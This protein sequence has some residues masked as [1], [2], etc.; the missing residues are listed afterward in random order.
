MT[1]DDPVRRYQDVIGELTAAAEELRAR[2]GARAAELKRELVERDAA[3]VAAQERAALSRLAVELRWEQ[4][5]EA[6]WP[7]S[8]MTLRPH[9][10]PDLMADPARLDQLDDAVEAAADEVLAA[11]RRRLLGFGRR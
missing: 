3:M 2:D 5:L 8:W 9:P 1:P 4:V 7:E 10:R 6:L 11:V